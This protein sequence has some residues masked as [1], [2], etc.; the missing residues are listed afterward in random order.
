MAN[1]KQISVDESLFI[2]PTSEKEPVHLTGNKCRNCGE[3][4]FPQRKV[5]AKCF[6]EGLED[7]P[8]SRRGKVYSS[9]VVRRAPPPPYKLLGDFIPFGLGHVELPEGLVIPTL[10]TGCDTSKPLPIGTEVKM[11]IEKLEEDEEGRDVMIYKFKP[12]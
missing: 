11:T 3:V 6:Q 1:K 4:F 9:T 12:V 7:I 10:F 8:L 5:C 2:M